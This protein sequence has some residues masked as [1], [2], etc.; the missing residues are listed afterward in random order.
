MKRVVSVSG[1][2]DS[3][4]CYLLAL[5]RGKPFS[6]CFADTGHEAEQTYDYVRSLPERTGGPPIRTVK[7]DF[8]SKLAHR[9]A[10]LHETWSKL[11]IPDA[12]IERAIPY[13]HPTG[14]PFVD[15]SLYHGIF[16]APQQRYC[17]RDLKIV[18][19]QQQVYKPLLEDGEHVVS[20]QGIRAD[21]SRVRADMPMRQKANTPFGQ[22]HIL[23]PLMQWTMPD[24]LD[25]IGSHGIKINPLYSEGFTRVG[26]FPCIFARKE[27]I[28]LIARKYPAAIDRLEQWEQLLNDCGR[29]SRT[30]SFFWGGKD[31]TWSK[32]EPTGIR[33]IVDWASTAR[34]GKQ[35]EIVPSISPAQEHFGEACLESGACE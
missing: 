21:E 17:T 18:P 33:R 12:M 14:V 7:A 15:A 32:G 5:R 25:F 10:T 22:I 35:Y 26:C 30:A 16:P 29:V 24:V 8:T 11:G 23:R 27:E 1:G 6:A 19:I 2:K 4:A 3:T 31:P 20:W 34:G 28:D 13:L 9:R